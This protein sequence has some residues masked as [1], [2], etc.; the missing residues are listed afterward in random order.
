MVDR[1][2]KL[3]QMAVR[4]AA[5]MGC[6]WENTRIVRGIRKYTTFG[7]GK[8]AVCPILLITYAMPLSICTKIIYCINLH[9]YGNFH[10]QSK[11]QLTFG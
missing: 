8:I 3:P 4:G 10:W 6:Y 5:K 2:D 1:R 7:V 9:V 11:L